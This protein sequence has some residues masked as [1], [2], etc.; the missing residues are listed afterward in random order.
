[1][2]LYSFLRNF[3]RALPLPSP[4][5]DG[6]GGAIEPFGESRPMLSPYNLDRR[7][8]VLGFGTAIDN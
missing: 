8:S 4:A 7:T 3:G 2:L 6:T 1:M 5:S